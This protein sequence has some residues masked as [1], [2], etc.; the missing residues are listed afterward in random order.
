MRD[1]MIRLAAE[2]LTRAYAPYSKFAV[3]ACIRGEDDR[4]FTGCN[5]E[6]ASYGLTQCAEANA[7]AKM[8]SEGGRRIQEILILVPT[9]KLCSPCGACRQKLLEFAAPTTQVHMYNTQGDYCTLTMAELLPVSFGPTNLENND[10]TVCKR[11]GRL[12]SKEGS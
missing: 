8:V 12:H 3:G 9:K 6:N 7:I 2:V 1:Q 10:D 5:V 11:S 4:L